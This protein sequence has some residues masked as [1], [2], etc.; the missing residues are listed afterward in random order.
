MEK[1]NLNARPDVGQL[2]FGQFGS[3]LITGAGTPDEIYKAITPLEATVIVLTQEKG[4]G[5]L[6]LSLPAGLTVYGR[7]TSANV[8]SGSVLAYIG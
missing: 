2:Q 3:R 1:T 8:S 7:F 4:D 5:I 6:N